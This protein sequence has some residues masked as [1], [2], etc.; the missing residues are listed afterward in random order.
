MR[1][2]I[3]RRT[4]IASAGLGL[5]AAAA[6]SIAPAAQSASASEPFGYCLNMATIMG[7]NLPIEQEVEIAAKAGYAGIEPWVR[8]IE[9]YVKRGNKLADLNKKIADLG[10]SV[11]SAIGFPNWIDDDETKRAAGL[12]QMKREMG[13]VAEIGGKRIAA[14]AAGVKTAIELPN[15][16]ERYAKVCEL[17]RTT[18]VA[19][20]LE[21]WG[22]SK[23]LHRLG[24]VAYVLAEA[25][26]SNACAILDVYHIYAG[27]SDFT[28]LQTFDGAV[29]PVFHMNDYPADPPRETITDAD[30]VYP[31]D[32]VAPLDQ[33]LRTLYAIGCR[34]ALSVELFNRTYYKQDPLEVA[35]TALAKMK[36]AVRHALS[37]EARG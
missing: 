35:R 15:I 1:P 12:E 32:G 7:Q 13:M 28:G 37:N 17:G 25:G 31:G 11:E 26:Q 33:I 6:A 24:Q 3:S 10:L 27:G 14:P 18:G 20:G 8:K 21:L 4:L 29:L 36:A 5:G 16:A 34:G 19:P 30:R 9:D 23:S 22:R 2:Q